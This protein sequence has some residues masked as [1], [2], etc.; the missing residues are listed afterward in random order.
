MKNRFMLAPMTNTQ[1]HEDGTLSDEEY[2]WLMMRAEGGFG[3]VMTCAS[4]VQES[5]KGFSGQLGIF[6]DQH[7]PGHTRLAAAIKSHGSLAVIQLH[8]AGGRSPAELIGQS[9]VGPSNNEKYGTRAL[10]LDEVR[11]LCDDFIAAAV[12]AQKSGYDGVEIHGAHGYILA[13]FLSSS[14]NHRTDRYGGNLT[15][16]ARLIFE[17]VGGIRKACGPEFLLGV[18][19]SPERFGMVLPEILEISQRLCDEGNIDFLDISLWDCFKYPEDDAYKNKTLLEHVAD[20]DLKEVRLTVAGKIQ[21]G[22][23][24]QKIL[25]AGVDFV[26]I[27]KAAILHHDF[28]KQVLN[29][30]DFKPIKTPVSVDYLRKEGLSQAFIHYMHRWPDFV[31]SE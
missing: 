16:R 4:H 5:G 7:I 8:H 27:G 3:L 1:S 17:I 13:Q 26:S 18:R 23:D 25:N 24:V 2:R 12:R 10:T 14:L 29:N 22:R 15:N 19:L 20:I 21:T 30:L 6:G 9:P 28:P 31:A 11:Q